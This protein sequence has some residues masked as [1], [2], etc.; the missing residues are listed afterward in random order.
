M[1]PQSYLL[2]ARVI[3]V[4]V[5]VTGKT[6]MANAPLKAPAAAEPLSA[7]HAL[8]TRGPRS[9]QGPCAEALVF[10]SA[11]SC[12]SAQPNPRA[13]QVCP[14]LLWRLVLGRLWRRVDT[15]SLAGSRPV[16]GTVDIVSL[17]GSLSVNG[18]ANNVSLAGSMSGNSTADSVSLAGYKIRPVP[19]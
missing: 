4:A 14:T 8:H 18:A 1:T 17:A 6:C 19:A 10:K 12:P 15:V 11:A 3:V 16:S 5:V 2:S 13:P 7:G 9:L